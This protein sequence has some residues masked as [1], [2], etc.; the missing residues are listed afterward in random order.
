[1][2]PARAAAKI[3]HATGADNVLLAELGARTFYDSFA[4]DNSP[5]NMAAYLA[6]SF[7]PD[8]QAS[9]LADPYSC[10]L[11]AE[12]DGLAVGYAKLQPSTPPAGVHGPN[13]VELVRIY[14]EKEWIGRGIGGK[15]MQACIEEARRRGYQTIWLAVWERNTAA[16]AFYRKWGFAEVGTYTFLLGYDALTGIA[17]QRRC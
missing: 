13:P 15:L 8:K 5:E 2:K 14:A 7:S 9:E 3:R 12:I 6:S 1:M 16:Q 17:M 10:F 4:A 11:I